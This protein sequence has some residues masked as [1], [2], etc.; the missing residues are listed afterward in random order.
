VQDLPG[1]GVKSTAPE[2]LSNQSLKSA[3]E[4]AIRDIRRRNPHITLWVHEDQSKQTCAAFKLKASNRPASWTMN[5]TRTLSQLYR[6]PMPAISPTKDVSADSWR[7]YLGV[8]QTIAIF[9]IE[10]MDML[11]ASCEL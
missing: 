1:S 8:S 10:K 6:Q 5:D 2:A 11:R 9:A 7:Q 3:A 4:S